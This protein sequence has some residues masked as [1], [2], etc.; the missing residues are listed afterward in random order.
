MSNI[1]FLMIR[2]MT[3][4]LWTLDHHTHI[5][6]F[7]ELVD[8]RQLYRITLYAVELNFPFAPNTR[9]KQVPCGLQWLEWKNWSDLLRALAS[10]PA[11]H[12]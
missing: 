12:L 3:K 9:L 4:S 6:P 1:R 8:S 2:Y 10:T 5:L 11:E 7:H